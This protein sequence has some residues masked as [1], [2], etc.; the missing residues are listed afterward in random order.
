MEMRNHIAVLTAV[1]LDLQRQ[2][3]ALTQFQETLK[4][5]QTQMMKLEEIE[6]DRQP[7]ETQGLVINDHC[8]GGGGI[9]HQQSSMH[10]LSVREAPHQHNVEGGSWMPPA[11]GNEP[12]QPHLRRS[13]LSSSAGCPR[14]S[15]PASQ[16]GGGG[17][18]GGDRKVQFD[19]CPVFGNMRYEAIPSCPID[20]ALAAFVNQRVNKI[21]FTRVRPGVYLYGRMP[22]R[23]QLGTVPETQ[24]KRLEVVAKG[25]RYTMAN[26]I[27]L[28]EE[29]E[30][31]ALDQAHKTGGTTME[32][33]NLPGS[34]LDGQPTAY[35]SAGP[36]GGLSYPPN[37]SSLPS[38]IPMSQLGS[39]SL[40]SSKPLRVTNRSQV[41][42]SASL[43][44][45]NAVE[46]KTRERS[47]HES[48]G[49]MARE[50]LPVVS[51][52]LNR[53]WENDPRGTSVYRPAHSGDEED[54]VER[55]M[56]RDQSHYPLIL[57]E[58]QCG[59][60]M[61]SEEAME[62]KT[63]TIP[64]KTVEGSIRHRT[65]TDSGQCD[66]ESFAL[67]QGGG[68][69][70][71]GQQGVLMCDGERNK[72]PFDASRVDGE[73]TDASSRARNRVTK[74]ILQHRNL[75]EAIQDELRNMDKNTLSPEKGKSGGEGNQSVR[76]SRA[77]SMVKAEKRSNT[78]KGGKK[79]TLGRSSMSCDSHALRRR[80]M[81]TPNGP[82]TESKLK[83]SSH[84]KNPPE[85]TRRC[86]KAKP[87]AKKDSRE[88]LVSKIPPSSSSSL[89]S[90]KH[91]VGNVGSGT[92]GRSSEGVPSG[93]VKQRK[94]RAPVKKEKTATSDPKKRR[95]PTRHAI[96][97]S[98]VLETERSLAHVGKSRDLCMA[99]ES[100]VPKGR[101]LSSEVPRRQQT[102]SGP[103]VAAPASQEERKCD[104]E[105]G[106]LRV[107]PHAMEVAGLK[108]QFVPYVPPKVTK[109]F[110]PSSPVKELAP[111]APR[112]VTADEGASAL[113]STLRSRIDIARSQMAEFTS[114]VMTHEQQ[115]N[116]GR[117]ISSGVDPSK[118]SILS[119]LRLG[120]RPD[121]VY[122]VNY[123]PNRPGFDAH[124]SCTI[125]QQAPLPSQFYQSELGSLPGK[126][127]RQ[128][129]HLDR[130]MIRE[131]TGA[132][133]MPKDC[134]AEDVANIGNF[135]RVSRSPETSDVSPI[136]QG[137]PVQ[138][139][140]AAWYYGNPQIVRQPSVESPGGVLLQKRLEMLQ[141]G[142]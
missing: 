120:S 107:P 109:K 38:S 134:D 124:P 66:M 15:Q 9:S 2:A 127:D 44:A 27:K 86:T 100:I 131:P 121:D 63:Q 56:K 140:E 69:S 59:G 39:G 20:S 43:R 138:S 34:Q 10:D 12:Q 22:V 23:V 61:M 137:L 82:T 67:L 81:T 64:K 3:K 1:N 104:G 85:E 51:T 6:T 32:L 29:S 102:P 139:A 26:F 96:S 16:V 18:A 129:A 142:R 132:R 47:Y 13:S 122:P 79:P 128:S 11:E 125:R 113:S 108:L 133:L 84:S 80:S 45:H 111:V 75:L 68:A 99:S 57:S 53:Q 91:V 119:G 141:A 112:G 87:T 49:H 88:T 37:P 19:V 41:S 78:G 73:D 40:L 14:S 103:Q 62:R 24:A 60:V 7:E 83:G 25:R 76:R 98:L 106:S 33:S 4:K 17:G 117:R 55:A 126:G 42:K 90:T 114:P 123:A 70:L 48:Q 71:E 36:G 136:L 54:E 30:F 101:L 8:Q 135:Q 93:G 5:N 50:H 31:L 130:M 46:T 77:D 28:Y 115:T 105:T 94:S 118:S 116:D 35:T 74:Y 58:S 97:D 21:L 89:S 52:L 95:A 72:K 92:R 110:P 65:P